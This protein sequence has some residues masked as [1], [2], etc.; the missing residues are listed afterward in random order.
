[1]HTNTELA[2][3]RKATINK[4]R[5][6]AYRELP[7]KGIRYSMS[8]LRAMWNAQPQLFPKPIKLSAHKLVWRECDLDD[9]VAKQ[10]AKSGA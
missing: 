6:F 1:M 5:L 10:I 9:W 8:R 2:S 3:R 4:E 7:E